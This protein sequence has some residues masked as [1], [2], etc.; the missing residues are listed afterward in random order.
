MKANMFPRPE[1][2][3]AMNRFV[4]LE[5]YTDGTD[6][7]SEQNQKYQE[8]KFANAAIPFYAIVDADE[9]VVA[10][11]PGLTKNP[12]EYLAFLD[13]ASGSVQASAVRVGGEFIELGRERRVPFGQPALAQA[14]Q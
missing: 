5:L 14:G 12:A 1:I 9:K 13:S 4:L 3:D 7:A 8:D 11:F 2:R 6:A 10:S